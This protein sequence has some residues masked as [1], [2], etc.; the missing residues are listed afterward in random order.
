MSST[1][2]T[3]AVLE[4]IIGEEITV[5]VGV[6]AMAR[7][8]SRSGLLL[9]VEADP[10]RAHQLRQALKERPEALVCEEVLAANNGE[11]VRWNRFNDARLSGPIGLTLLRERFPNLEQNDEE[12]RL[13]RRLGDLLDN[14]APCQ[15]GKGIAKLHIVLRQGDPLAALGGLGPWHKQLETV[16]LILPWP[17]E[18]MRPVEAWLSEHGF[19]QDP[20]SATLWK[21]DPIAKGNWL[22]QEKGNEN[23]VLIAANQQLHSDCEA[24]RA[25]KEFLAA[26]LE[27]VSAQLQELRRAQDLAL[28][29]IQ[30]SQDEAEKFRKQ[31]EAL[32]LEWQQLAT[33][34]LEL[35][36]RYKAEEAAGL[37][38]RLALKCLFPIQLYKEGN[39]DLSGHDEDGLVLH[40]VEHG[41][42]EGRLKTYQ[43][44]DA[45][46]KSRQEQNDKTEAKLEQLEEHFRLAQQQ[47]E[48][49]KDVFARLANNQLPARHKKGK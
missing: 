21:L 29:D 43:E 22:L 1:N 3:T 35:L 24:M 11:L 6:P 7:G 2:S 45:E 17:E 34:K 33:D 4:N 8:L 32:Q 44:L 9:V 26:R 30:K 13:G 28:I 49:L 23:K 18:V 20:Q 15:S 46:L 47:I 10:E 36:Q 41:R 14:W 12:E 39:I 16:Q 40:Y 19:C 37:N 5:W 27:E 42:G 31:Q 48:T 38:I 25:E